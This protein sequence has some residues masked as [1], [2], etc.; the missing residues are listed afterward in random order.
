M[1]KSFGCFIVGGAVVLALVV[2]GGY[3]VT[4]YNMLVTASE[5]IDG[6]WAQVENVLQRRA[7]LIPN[8]VETVKGFAAQERGIFEEIAEARSR[9]IGAVAGVAGSPAEAAKADA[10]LNSALGRLLAIAEAY[11]DLKS[12]QNFIRLQ[13][14]L[15]GTENRIAVERR[16]YND[17]V[18][19]FNASIK[20]FPTNIV[21]RWFG[22]DE[23]EYFEASPGA[24]EAPKVEF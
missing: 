9:L 24:A 17:T 6:A 2:L 11:P 12:N 20:R 14:E 5:N 1:K 21:A 3:A 4:R 23:R 15:A 19:T 18:R 8:L 16:A 13:D 22:F 7:D 10:A